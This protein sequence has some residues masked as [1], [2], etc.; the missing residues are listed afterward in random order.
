MKTVII[1]Y[2]RV[3]KHLLGLSPSEELFPSTLIGVLWKRIIELE[4]KVEMLNNA[5]G[6]PG[7]EMARKRFEKNLNLY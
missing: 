3:Y 5:P 7:Y 2:C 4:N 1:S 6:M